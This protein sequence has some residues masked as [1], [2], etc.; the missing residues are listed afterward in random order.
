MCERMF[1]KKNMNLGVCIFNI[2][3]SFVS[4][5]QIYSI[6]A[7]LVCTLFEVFWVPKTGC[8]LESMAH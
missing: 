6:Y 2:L 7:N 5:T 1:L 3:F 4:V 8:A